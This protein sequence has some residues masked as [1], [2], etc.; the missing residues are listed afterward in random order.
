MTS[1]LDHMLVTQVRYY[2][3]IWYVNNIPIM[4]FWPEFPEIPSQNHIWIPWLGMPEDSRIMHCG[5]FLHVA[6]AIIWMKTDCFVGV[7]MEFYQKPVAIKCC[8]CRDKNN[9]CAQAVAHYDCNW[10]KTVYIIP[11]I[12]C[13]TVLRDCSTELYIWVT[14]FALEN[15]LQL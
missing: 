9:I 1:I 6:L 15:V 2:Y 4:K 5:I 13:T 7:L 11:S 12:Q 10:K 8:L 3:F 14:Y